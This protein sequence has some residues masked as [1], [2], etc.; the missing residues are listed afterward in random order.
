MS[1]E[2]E[3]NGES[4]D[5][6]RSHRERTLERWVMI[7]IATFCGGA[8]VCGAPGVSRADVTADLGAGQSVSS[9][10][11]QGE[12]LQEVVV[13]AQKKSERLQDVP[14]P[15]TVLNG[16][17]LAADNR[18]TLPD[19]LASVPGL[20]IQTNSGGTG[21]ELVEIRGLGTSQFQN[22][23]APTV[24]FMIDG[25]P[26]GSTEV[27][28]SGVSAPGIPDIDPSEIERI[29]VLKGPQ[30]TLYGADS[31]GGLINVVTKDPSTAGF[32][33]H[34]QAVG[35]DI[36]DGGAGYAIRGA[37]NIPISNDLAIRVGGFDRR[38]PGYIDNVTDNQK[39]VNS[40]DVYG[41]HFALLYRPSDSLSFKFSALIGD[42]RSNGAGVIN[43]DKN[44]TP[45]F[46]GL[47]Q[48]GLP[49]AGVNDYQYQVYSGVINAKV[50]GV[51]VVSMTS[52]NVEKNHHI[53]DYTG[54]FSSF[55]DE[56]FPATAPNGSLYDANST[57]DKFSQEI[58]LSSSYSHWID[59]AVGGF[60]TYE[61]NS[62]VTIISAN[63]PVTGAY[64]GA[65]YYEAD[66]H[67]GNPPTSLSEEAAYGDL[68]A[69]ITRQFDI[70]F[71]GRYSLYQQANNLF[72]FGPASPIF[73]GTLQPE[74]VPT[75]KGSANP[76][77]YLVTPEYKISQN[78][79]V[80]ARIAT[81]YQI[82]GVNANPPPGY[83]RTYNP[84]KTINYEV[85]TK[86]TLA[87]GRLAFD[88]SAYYIDW[89]QLQ[90]PTFTD[91]R[92]VV[93]NAA[94]AKSQGIEASLQAHPI[95]GLRIAATGSYNDAQVTTG[96]P[97]TA[98]ITASAGTQLP[99]S[100]HWSGSLSADWD[101]M[102]FAQST[103]FV[104]GRLSYIGRRPGEF[105]GQDGY[106]RLMFPA[107]TTFDA[108]IGL[109]T[110]T[111]QA[112]LYVK[113]LGD[114]RGFTG[115]AGAYGPTGNTGQYYAQVIQP[116]TIGLSIS[117]DF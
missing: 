78:L 91:Y 66:G 100:M 4:I 38:D 92:G 3:M 5:S 98:G 106:A 11:S 58:R 79:M 94:A 102:H 112:L 13:T 21:G 59:W 61:T 81:G 57:T 83:S 64:V 47:R 70:Q 116:R 62:G 52:Y 22:G 40:A 55:A 84:S 6:G 53:F 73:G 74:P 65:F 14:V 31:L 2:N 104:G 60:Y 42:D 43:V 30:G 76:F 34:I 88:L 48:T 77:T 17:D 24:G 27:I 18:T 37:V 10:S 72:S 54:D 35:E 117:K 110:G 19:Y 26:Y 50:A 86:G 12:S 39:N 45:Q 23:S 67:Y 108:H 28:E 93:V 101:A 85:G 82:G 90:V 9:G 71:G 15:V 97:S 115:G 16:D 56:F 41:G 103:A 68:T 107:Y 29:E 75:L 113:N 109:R 20:N 46:S 36:P 1:P 49:G 95:D 51:D 96:F 114:S 80:Y 111:L 87:D 63:N 99:Y 44:L 8:L 69:H 89:T 33:G 105:D 32:S 7:L 25:M